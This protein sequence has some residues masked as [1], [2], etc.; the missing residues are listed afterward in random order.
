M[1]P[2][3]DRYHYTKRRYKTQ[4]GNRN[5]F[6]AAEM[7]PVCAGMHTFPP[8]ALKKAVDFSGNLM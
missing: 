7:F 3:M 5:F 1:Y 4:G 8:A 6:L 2:K